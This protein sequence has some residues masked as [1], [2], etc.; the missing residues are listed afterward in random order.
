M[1]TALNVGN[2]EVFFIVLWGGLLAAMPVVIGLFL[3]EMKRLAGP[4]GGP[5]GVVEPRPEVER[6]PA[7]VGRPG[8]A[9]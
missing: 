1:F 6:R 4:A 8:K 5:A 3:L 2:P 9:A 7:E